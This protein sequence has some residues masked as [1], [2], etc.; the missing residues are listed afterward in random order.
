MA[1]ASLDKKTN[2]D[3]AI[4]T[5]SSAL[6]ECKE[7]NMYMGL[8]EAQKQTLMQL[9]LPSHRHSRNAKKQTCTW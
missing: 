1:A 9:S 5:L 4:T 2:I 3:A 7:T 8:P 6:E